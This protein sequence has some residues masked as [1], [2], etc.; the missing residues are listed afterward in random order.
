MKGVT[1]SGIGQGLSL[2]GI[3]TPE[4]T[5]DDTERRALDAERQSL[6]AAAYGARPRCLVV[7]D[8]EGTA[9]RMLGE[10][11]SGRSGPRLL[12]VLESRAL[13]EEVRPGTT[14]LAP[15]IAELAPV[16]A[17]DLLADAQ[18]R[19]FLTEGRP[20][21]AL[22]FDEAP[23]RRLAQVADRTVGLMLREALLAQ[24]L[25]AL[26]EFARTLVVALDQGVIA[27]D[28]EGRVAY[29]NREAEETLGFEPG[30]AIGLD[31]TRVLRPTVGEKHP[32][33]EG[34]AGRLRAVHLY[35]TDRK[36]RDL[37]LAIQ[38]RRIEG[39]RGEG[40]GLIALLRNLSDEQALD[41][42]MQQRERLAVIGEL[43]AGVAHEIRNPLTG[44]GNCAQVLQER[45]QADERNRKLADLILR[46]T[47][48]LDRIVTSLLGFA[49]PGTPRMQAIAIG[50]VAERVLELERAACEQAGIRIERRVLGMIPT[51]YVDPE[52]I[53]QVLVNLVRNAVQSM[54]DGG[55]LAVE[56]SVVRRRLQRRR[57]IGRRVTDRIRIVGEPP[58][59]RF[60]RVR[61]Q[62][63]G[64]GIPE[65]ALPRIFDPF[66]TTRSEGT[67]LGLSVSQTIV[68]EH[69][70][71]LSVQSVVGKGTLFDVDLP[72]E[73]RQGGRR[74]EDAS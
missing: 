31:C 64:V 62:D 74:E 40:R 13:W 44:I 9:H 55:V 39:A 30:E 59:V 49:R 7:I 57:G 66:F 33:L 58:L 45:L 73:R 8:H 60:V 51:I 32:L 35:I 69:G 5:G 23:A 50:E 24:E 70:G 54:P 22:V 1:M 17:P 72:V 28:E 18:V 3:A 25:S 47:Q 43:A 12:E 53:Q 63:T 34:L 37:P 20:L 46:E 52:Q 2:V 10:L 67:G 65:E 56:I 38:M 42:S 41:Q 4:Q 48:R 6:I 27:V 19:F 16:W 11:P 26:R 15:Q 71:Y 68:Q 61:V 29:L 21:G 14:Y 36:G